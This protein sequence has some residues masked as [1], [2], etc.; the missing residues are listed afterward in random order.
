VWRKDDATNV[1]A[2]MKTAVRVALCAKVAGDSSPSV[3]IFR[4]NVVMNAVE[5]APSAI[6]RAKG[7]VTE[8]PSGRRP[9]FY[10]RRKVRPKTCSRISPKEA[11]AHTATPTTPVARVIYSLRLRRTIGEQRTTSANYES[12]KFTI[13]IHGI[14]GV[15]KVGREIQ[16][17]PR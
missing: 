15:V 13:E 10:R 6:N 1:T 12:K 14:L 16:K 8:T 9:G 3:A 4:E 2:L 11:R 5:R 7:S 17:F